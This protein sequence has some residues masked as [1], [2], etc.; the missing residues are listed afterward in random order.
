MAS[1]K[2]ASI[3]EKEIPVEDITPV[4]TKQSW[5]LLNTSNTSNTPTKETVLVRTQKIKRPDGKI[6][7]TRQTA[8][9]EEYE[10]PF[11]TSFSSTIRSVNTE[12]YTED[13]EYGLIPKFLKCSRK[14]KKSVTVE[15]PCETCEAY[16]DHGGCE[17]RNTTGR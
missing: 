8:R 3:P 2:I 17:A 4:S 15:T 6:K 12:Q 9:E 11:N 13:P 5:E 1:F 7:V 14:R 10:T 16:T